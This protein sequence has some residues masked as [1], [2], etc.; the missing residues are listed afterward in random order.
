MPTLRIIQRKLGRHGADG[1][2]LKGRKNAII[3]IDPRQDPK[4]EL[5][6]LIHEALHHSFPDLDEDSVEK[7]AQE[8]TEIAWAYNFRK[9]KQ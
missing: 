2:Y 8:I 6:T 7:A 1:R 9:V 4:N 5:D 3:E